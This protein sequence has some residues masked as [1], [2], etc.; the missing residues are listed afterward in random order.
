MALDAIAEDVFATLS[1]AP[2]LPPVVYPNVGVDVPAAPHLRVFI[3]PA[4]T[5]TVGLNSFEVEQGIIQISV[6]E[7][8]GQGAIGPYATAELILNTVFPRGFSTL[9]FRVIKAGSLGPAIVDGAWYVVPVSISYIN[10]R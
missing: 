5:D 1:A 10:V 4:N 3:L 9:N 7:A 2:G 8:Q 6:Y